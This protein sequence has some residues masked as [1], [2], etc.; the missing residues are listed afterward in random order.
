[1]VTDV[2]LKSLSALEE[3]MLITQ[4]KGLLSARFVQSIYIR[5]D[6][7]FLGAA[8]NSLI[9]LFTDSFQGTTL[10]EYKA[11]KTLDCNENFGCKFYLIY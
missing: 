11:T 10:E 9:Y 2:P 6:P 5:N 8:P 4:V 1:M 7:W 3:T